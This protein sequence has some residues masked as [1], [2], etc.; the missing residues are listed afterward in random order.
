MLAGYAVAQ[1]DFI[2]D[3]DDDF[4]CPTYNV[5][6]LITPLEQDQCDVSIARYKKKKESFIKRI[7]SRVNR[8]MTEVLLNKPK[9]IQFE[10]FSCRKRFVCEEM[11]KYKNPFPFLEGLTLRVTHRISTFEMEQRN[12][13]DDKTTGFTFKKS[14]SLLLNG[15]TAF[16]VKPLRIAT[17]TGLLVALIGFI[18]GALIIIKRL[19]NPDVVV[20]YTSII[21]VL[22]FLGGLNMIMLGLIGEY[23]GR[24]YI[25][26]NDSPQY[27]IK[28]TINV[29]NERLKNA[30]SNEYKG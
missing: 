23:I 22:L 3:L 13:A 17:I 16:S 9:N 10:N 29:N 27:V 28:N 15:L 2:V 21:S 5:W 7:G 25:S 4:Q 24:I 1:G 30:K 20:G 11:T 26:I 18:L 12:R 8:K 19:L 6:K 14:F